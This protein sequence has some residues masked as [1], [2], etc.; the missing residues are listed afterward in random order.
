MLGTECLLTAEV[1]SNGRKPR[2][3]RLDEVLNDTYCIQCLMRKVRSRKTGLL[4]ELRA[5][6]LRRGLELVF[7]FVVVEE[8]ENEEDIIP[9]LPCIILLM[10]TEMLICVTP[11]STFTEKSHWYVRDIH[12]CVTSSGSESAK[13]L[14]GDALD[15]QWTHSLHCS[16]SSSQSSM[17]RGEG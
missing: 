10:T 13:L 11:A 7:V 2:N 6:S 8:E 3:I 9:Y 4:R 17:R 5:N 16:L 14:S 1:K 12:R 15:V